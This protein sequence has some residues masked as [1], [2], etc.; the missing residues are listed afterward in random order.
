MAARSAAASA[1]ASPIRWTCE[2]NASTCALPV[3]VSRI[4]SARAFSMRPWARMLND[5]STA[6]TRSASPESAGAIDR[7][8]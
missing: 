2:S 8:T 1:V 7:L 6:I 5:V 3:P 4:A